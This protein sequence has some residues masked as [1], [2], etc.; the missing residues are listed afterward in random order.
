MILT[1]I[2]SKKYLVGSDVAGYRWE[3]VLDTELSS[4]KGIF[5]KPKERRRTMLFLQA[6]LRKRI[7]KGTQILLKC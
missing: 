6:I 1:L 7:L 2:D 4:S 5:A 3:D